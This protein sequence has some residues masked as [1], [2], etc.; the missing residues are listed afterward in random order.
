VIPL[1]RK[2]HSPRGAYELSRRQNC[3]YSFSR[4]SAVNDHILAEGGGFRFENCRNDWEP[5]M[6]SPRFFLTLVAVLPFGADATAARLSP[7]QQPAMVTS[8]PAVVPSNPL[9][10]TRV[11]QA[12]K[13]PA[14]QDDDQD[15]DQ[16]RDQYQDRGE[17]QYQYQDR[18]EDRDQGQDDDD[19][20]DRDQDQG[21]SKNRD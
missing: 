16:N 12:R 15:E 17:D 21:R 10:Q 5:S 6:F 4:Y 8:T 19:D 7:E 3:R 14:A 18:G 13:P 9:P 2:R 1:A 11:A 20:Y